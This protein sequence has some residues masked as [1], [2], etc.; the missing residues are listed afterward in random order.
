M[1]YSVLQALLGLHYFS[2]ADL[3]GKFV[4]ISK[5]KWTQEFLL[6]D[7]KDLFQAFTSAGLKVFRPETMP[8][9]MLDPIEKFVLTV[10]GGT[11][12]QLFKRKKQTN[13]GLPPTRATLLQH[14]CRFTY[15]CSVAKS[16]V[17]FC[18]KLESAHGKGKYRICVI[19]TLLAI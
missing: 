4:G 16:Y 18:P 17:E 19:W 2:S 3:G 11:R 15:C 14:C 12:W 1:S 13:E 6:S 8:K 9:E 10:Y 5:L 7:D